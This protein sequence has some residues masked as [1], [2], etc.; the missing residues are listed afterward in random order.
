MFQ[1]DFFELSFLAEACIPPRPISRSMFWTKL[2]DEHYQKMTTEERG[3]LYTWITD[4]SQFKSAIEKKDKD[5]LLFEAR[6]NPDNQFTIVYEF[7]G[8]RY[9]QECFF[10]EDE[11]HTKSNVFIDKEY[12]VDKYKSG[13]F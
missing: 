5:A 7:K 1:I 2:I 10:F 8:S 4:C 3:R 12:I 9:T 6:F 11:F 13:T